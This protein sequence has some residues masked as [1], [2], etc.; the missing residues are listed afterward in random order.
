MRLIIIY[1]Q[2]FHSELFPRVTYQKYP[3]NSRV[4]NANLLSPSWYLSGHVFSK[5]PFALTGIAL[6]LKLADFWI[7]ILIVCTLSLALDC[8]S[9][10]PMFAILWWR[11]YDM[12]PLVV[13]TGLLV[14][15]CHRFDVWTSSP[16]RIYF[17]SCTIGTVRQARDIISYM[18]I[19]GG[20]CITR[21]YNSC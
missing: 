21:V 17:M 14:A 6:R 12:L 9:P 15:Y 10:L 16:K 11:C 18:D 8:L 19:S 5:A 20:L 2:E 1:D 4:Q 7:I 13:E 3:F